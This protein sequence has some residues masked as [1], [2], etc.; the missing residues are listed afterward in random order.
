VKKVTRRGFFQSA[1]VAAAAPVFGAIAAQAQQQPAPAD[2][3]VERD[4]VYGKGGDMELRL[5][6]YRPPAGVTAKKMAVIHIHGGGF[7]Q[8]SKAG[9][10][11]SSRAF[12]GIGYVSIASQDRLSGQAKWPAQIEDVKAAIRWTRANASRLGIDADK[13][14]VAGYSAGGLMALV[15]AGT[16]DKKELEGNGGNPGVSSKVAACVSFYAAVSANASLFPEGTDRA[17]IDAAGAANTISPAFAPTIFLHGLSDTTIRPESTLE[18]FQKVRAAGVKV[19]LH[20]FQ[21]APHAYETSN[22]DAALAS[23]QVSNL[24]FDRLILNPKEYPPFGG[25]GRGGRGGGRGG[26]PGGAGGAGRGGQQ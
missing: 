18:F 17:T 23:A 9:V 21:G 2:P 26:A 14:A 15:A 4:V 3:N 11:G 10:A 16:G 25:G 22:P 12:S 1:G 7:T 24:F 5:D 8:G 6:I 19:D 13:I 20:F